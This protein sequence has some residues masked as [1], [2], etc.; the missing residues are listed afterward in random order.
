MAHLH[1][2]RSV[3]S[4]PWFAVQVRDGNDNDLGNGRFVDDTVRKVLYLATPDCTAERLPRQREF[5]DAL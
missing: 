4:V 5:A 1:V 3:L 2:W